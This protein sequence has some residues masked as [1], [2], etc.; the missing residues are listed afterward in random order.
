MKARTKIFYLVGIAVL[1]VVAIISYRRM[2]ATEAEPVIPAPNPVKSLVLGGKKSYLYSFSQP[3]YDQALASDKVVVLYF[4]ANW[5]PICRGEEP[6]II[7]GF[8]ELDR[9]DIVGL[10][11]NFND[12]E[13][14]AFEKE[15]A[16]KY[17][18]TYQHTKIFLKDGREIGRSG[19]PWNKD[20]FLS[21]IE[22]LGS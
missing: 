16:K 14:D 7:D 17:G 4:Y 1:L 3:F 20:D 22:R 13:T 19:V 18:V 9:D 12:S 8:N 11:V 15:L 10:R 6:L 2:P 21:E 5:C